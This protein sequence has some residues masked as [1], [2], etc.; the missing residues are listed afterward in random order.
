[1]TKHLKYP[2]YLFLALL[3]AKGLY[4]IIESFYNYHVLVTTTSADLTKEAVEAL[5]I[6]GHRISSVG[7]TLLLIPLFYFF[8]KQ[9]SERTIYVSL[10]IASILTYT[11]TYNMLNKVVDYI[12]ESNKEKRH[13]A[14]YVNVFKYGLLNNAFQYDSFIDNKKIQEDNLDVDDRILLTNSFLL[15]HADQNLIEKLQKKGKEKFA[16]V[17][18][19]RYKQDDYTEQFATFTKA[20]Q[21]LEALWAKIEV[22]KDKVRQKLKIHTNE[23]KIKKVHNELIVSLNKSYNSYKKAYKNAHK[24]I[25]EETIEVKLKSIKK[26]LQ[27]YFRYSSYNSA[28]KKYKEKMNQ[29]FEH[30]IEPRRWKNSNNKL[31]YASIKEV[32]KSEILQKVSKKT[33]GVPEGLGLK[34]FSENFKVKSEVSRKLKAKGILIPFKFDYTYES[35]KK[36]YKF[37]MIKKS[38]KVEAIFKKE[39]TKQIGKND[40]TLGMDWIEYVNSDFIQ[41]KIR[42]QFG[43]TKEK[44][45]KAIIKSLEAHDLGDFRKLVYLPRVIDEIEKARYKPEDFL[46]GAKAEKFGD[47][48]VKLLYIPPFALAV[49]IMALLLNLVTFI[50]MLL[51]YFKVSSLGVNTAKVMLF[52][53]IVFLPVVTQHNGFN[54][55]LMKKVSN[56]EV[57][58]YLSFLNWISYYE[59]INSKWH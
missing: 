23:A 55:T 25:A 52:I 1:M 50:G 33:N 3:S 40:F 11:L 35:F 4:V 58:T 37:A 24:K 57:Q 21:E 41:N 22:A 53:F 14:Y 18:I 19:N 59:G 54:N 7:I 39:L 47:E 42:S 31:T 10:A 8:V 51:R 36:Y 27:E 26:D 15:L 29:K 12:V 6:N 38:N 45:F 46:D 20:T 17:Y 2:I 44:Y 30:Y 9:K 32:I 43:N 56:P 48:A 34:E 16:E 28:K 5:N 13:D 49:S